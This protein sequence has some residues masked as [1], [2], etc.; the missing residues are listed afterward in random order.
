MITFSG[1]LTAARTLSY[2]SRRQEIT[3]N[4]L[5]NATTAGFKADR[6][7]AHRP[8]DLESPIPVAA[9][10]LS[11]G[12][13][14]LTG[15]PLDI[16]LEGQGFLVVDT[17]Q[18]ERLTRGGSLRLDGAGI[19]VTDDG[20]PV[21]GEQGPIAL[22]GSRIEIAPDGTVTDDGVA[23]DTLRLVQLDDCGQLLKEGTSRYQ[24]AAEPVRATGTMVRQ[25][26]LEEANLDSI[27]GMVSLVEIQ[28]A[29]AASVTTLRTMDGVLGSVTTDVAR[30]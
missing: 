18:G 29:Y 30:V 28:R 19:L 24:T 26:Q 11:Q 16:A 15:R 10:D 23:V 20:S 3:A 9:T 5:A 12:A 7:V 14:R 17:P 8:G 27:G 4:N 25:G 21:L 22:T 1:L 13:L 6:I 2:Y